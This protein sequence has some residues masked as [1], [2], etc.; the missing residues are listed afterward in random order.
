ME[1]DEVEVANSSN[2]S[3]A[4]VVD[5]T[6]G[7]KAVYF[8][9]NQVAGL[10]QHVVAGSNQ[11]AVAGSS[12]HAPTEFNPS[13]AGPVNQIGGIR[14]FSQRTVTGA[15]QHAVAGSSHQFAPAESN[16]AIEDQSM[17]NG[18]GKD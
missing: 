18:R 13:A 4:D 7:T 12:K 14:K 1:I 2:S 6:N 17:L 5:R 15:S 16:I 8:N 10:S 9:S 11:H 3:A